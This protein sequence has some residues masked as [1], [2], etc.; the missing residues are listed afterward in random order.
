MIQ[1]CLQQ[2]STSMTSKQTTPKYY[3]YYIIIHYVVNRS[4]SFQ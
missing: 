2:N 1:L 3:K 4:D